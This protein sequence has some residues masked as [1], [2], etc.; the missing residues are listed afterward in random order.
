MKGLLFLGT[1]FAFVAQSAMAA[2]EF[3]GSLCISSVSA[4]CTAEGWNVGDCLLLRYSP[5]NIGTNGP[6]TELS[7]LGQ[8][9]ADNYSLP[10]GS[11]VGTV[12]KPVA[13]THVGRT[14]Y[15]FDSQMRITSQS[16]P[17]SASSNSVTISGNFR[18]FGGTASCNIAFRASG[19]RRP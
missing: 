14:G 19:T 8:S 7:L 10:S 15:S 17:P 5:P 3:R 16:P 1:A 18:N 6:K 4:A 13:G 9:F 12:F 2:T 11:L